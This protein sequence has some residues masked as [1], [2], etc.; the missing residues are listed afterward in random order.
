MERIIKLLGEE[1]LLRVI[2]EEVDIDL[3]IAHMAYIEVKKPDSKAL[4]FTKPISKKLGKKFDIPVLMNVFGS[5][6]ATELVFGKNPNDVSKQIQE[7]L[8]MKPPSGFF[9]K[10][11]M[12][13]TLL[14]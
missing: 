9:D 2:D 13:G 7:L 1:G 12:L 11:S 4:L 10:I 6:K 14:G 8:H 3:E 5:T